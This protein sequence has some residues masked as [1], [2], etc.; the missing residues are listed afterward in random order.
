MSLLLPPSRRCCRCRERPTRPGRGGGGGAGAAALGPVPACSAWRGLG[1]AAALLPPTA[2]ES[3]PAARPS[4]STLPRGAPGEPVGSMAGRGPGGG[5]VSWSIWQRLGVLGGDWEG[6]EDAWGG[7]GAERGEGRGGEGRGER[8]LT[9]EGR[10][11]GEASGGPRR[12]PD[13]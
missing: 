6:E 9:S 2:A 10:R 11:G 7:R 8:S 12:R 13:A 1:A 5:P 4:E 3:L